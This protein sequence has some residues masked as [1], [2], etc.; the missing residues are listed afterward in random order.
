MENPAIFIQ[1]DEPMGHMGFWWSYHTKIGLESKFV[2]ERGQYADVARSLCNI[3]NR[4]A[5][6][7]RLQ[8]W[9]GNIVNKLFVDLG[10]INNGIPGLNVENFL[11]RGYNGC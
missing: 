8:A 7:N 3:R 9:L 11:C 4:T 5:T 6:M 1:P 10:P 2:S